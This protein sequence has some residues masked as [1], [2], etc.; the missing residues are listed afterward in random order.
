MAKQLPAVL[1]NFN[2]FVDGDS[3][4]GLA[5]TIELPEL[6]K[7]TEE[8]RGAGMIGDIALDMGFEKLEATITYT[9]IDRRHFAQLAKCGVSDL[10][11]R[12]I[13]A[14]ERQDTCAHVTRE[15]YMRGSLTELPLGE[16]ELGSINEQ[17]L[18]YNLTYLKIIDDNAVMLE[19]DLVN[20]V[21][22]IAGIDKTA[23][24]NNMLGL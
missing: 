14:Y 6:V 19:L 16:M 17:E 3:Y 21:C 18:K 7:K 4:A 8:Y 22:V 11:I 10:P 13:G 15:I 12:F 20:G 24:I 9:G 2:V 5:K 1:K 23:E